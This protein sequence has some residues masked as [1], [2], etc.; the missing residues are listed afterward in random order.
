ME[1]CNKKNDIIIKSKQ[2]TTT[3]FLT[4][5]CT[6]NQE[7]IKKNAQTTRWELEINKT[8]IFWKEYFQKYFTRYTISI[9]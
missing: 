9:R 5:L 6:L 2:I 8:S 3:Q 1:N 7:I 4:M